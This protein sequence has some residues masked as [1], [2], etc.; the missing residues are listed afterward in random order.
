MVKLLPK[1]PLTSGVR[2]EN[3]SATVTVIVL[4]GPT[5]PVASAQ[6]ITP[7]AESAQAVVTWM[8]F[9]PRCPWT[10]AS[11]RAWSSISAS[12]FGCTAPNAAASR[13]AFVMWT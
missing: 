6:S 5:P 4:P 13:A 2:N 10:L 8:G 3:C 11:W 1:K 12:T 7:P 9:S